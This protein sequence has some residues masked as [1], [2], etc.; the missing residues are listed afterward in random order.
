VDPVALFADA[1]A[2]RL[3]GDLAGA[4]AGYR[5]L[6]GANRGHARAINGM[7][8]L[9][10][11]KGQGSAALEFAEI[12]LALGPSQAAFLETAGTALAQLGRLPQALARYSQALNLAPDRAQTHYMKGSCLWRMG[13]VDEATA[14]IDRAVALDSS[15]A[16]IHST[17][18]FEVLSACDW[19]WLD[20]IRRHAV[21]AVRAGASVCDPFTF[22]LLTRSPAEQ[23]LASEGYATRNYPPAPPLADRLYDHDRIRVAY[24]SGDL[25]VHAV[26]FV[27]AGIFEAHDR[28]RFEWIG[29]SVGPNTRSAIRDRVIAGFDTFLDLRDEDDDAI[30][31]RMRDMEIDIAIDLKGYTTSGRPGILARRPASI[32]VNHL[33]FAATM[34]TPYHDY[35]VADHDI[36]PPGEEPHYTEAVVRLPDTYFPTDR[37]MAIAQD[38]PTKAEAGLPPDAF[39]F[40]AFNKAYKL[41]PEIFEVWLNILRQ[42]DGSVL[43]LTDGGEAMRANLQAFA[44]ARD[45]DPRRLF[46][47]ARTEARE[48]HLA[49]QRAADLYLDSLPYNGHTTA[50]D[51][52]WAGL[53]VLTCTGPT[54]VGRVG[55]SLL[56]ALE[57]PELI[58]ANL[59]AYEREAVTL[60][61]SPALL[62]AIRARLAV[63]RLTTPL[64]DTARWCRH[65]EAALLGMVEQK[66][67]GETPSGFDVGG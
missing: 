53:P 2:R 40:C 22:T 50:V 20:A 12:A 7:A 58:T 19:T 1:E 66:R 51:A 33:G 41:G 47:A 28:D 27:T 21:G 64:F 11:A 16:D 15:I 67:R 37:N 55:T 35:V 34:G 3:S 13:R 62:A 65:M 57:L 26:S 49:R 46:F 63:N 8:Q 38:R 54:F 18:T 36:I 17:S 31:R 6:L 56:H 14:S 48:D 23:R 60:A 52:L 5:A 29:V 39:V 32:Q 59:A 25:H 30:A 10:L 45:I 24:V 61:R 43:W 9:A 42:V 44:A 4:E